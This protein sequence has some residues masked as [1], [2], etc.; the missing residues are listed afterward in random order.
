MKN[1]LLLT[2]TI[3]VFIQSITVGQVE[4]NTHSPKKMEKDLKELLDMVDAHPDPFAKITEEDFNQIVDV[5][6]QNIT[7]ELDEVDFY[8]NLSRI[9][10]AISDGHSRLSMPRHWL[11]NL[12]KKHG[13]FPYEIFV[14]NKNELFIIKSYGDENLPLGVQILEI[15]GM[16]VDSMINALNPYISYETI[17]FR[18]D[19]I[20]ESFELMLYLI[21]KQSSNLKFKTANSEVIIPSIPFKDWKKQKKDNR[22]EREKKIGIGEPYEFTILEPGVGKIDIFSFSVSDIDKYNFFLNKTFKQIKKNNIHSLIIDVRGN[23]GGWPKI[24]SELFHYIH[25]GYFKTMAKSSMKISYPYRNYFTRRNPSLRSGNV[26]LEQKRHYVDLSSVLYGKL[27]SYVDEDLFFN[28]TPIMETYEFTGDCYLLIDRKSYSASSAF[29]STFQCYTMGFIIGE[30]TGGTKIFRANAIF[31]EL[32]RTSI[33]AAMSTTKL[34][35]AC[36]NLEDEPVNP[37]IVVVPTITDRVFD[38]DPQLIT[39]LLLIKKMQ[40]AKADME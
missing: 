17:P 22:E 4:F 39:A 5:V 15:N 1:R 7:K 19:K 29:A 28:E 16:S 34:Y 24:A 18:N 32:P 3:F 40:K 25:N 12:M 30:P 38:Q 31:K 10:A 13:V 23:Y 6:K 26:I 35:T 21:F 2:I 33:V 14:T 8:K 36:Y 20:T 27:D 11:K 37:N 9:V